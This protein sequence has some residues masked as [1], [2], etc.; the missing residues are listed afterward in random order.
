MSNQS[1]FG[2]MT[3]A[4]HDTNHTFDQRWTTGWSSSHEIDPQP[5]FLQTSTDTTKLLTT[6]REDIASTDNQ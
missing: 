6:Y 5:R 1:Y 4:V 2:R 3:I